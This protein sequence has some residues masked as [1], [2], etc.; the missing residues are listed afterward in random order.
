[1]VRGVVLTVLASVLTI[2]ACD[3]KPTVEKGSG[4]PGGRSVATGTASSGALGAS[5][6]AAY[7]CEDGAYVVA[8][9]RT[10]SDDVALFLPGETVFLPQ[11]EAASGAKYS[12]GALTFWSRAHEAMLGRDGVTVRCIENRQASVIEKAKLGGADFWAA[13]N[14]PGWTL[15][16]YPDR[17][18]LVTA[19]GELRIESPVGP[20]VVDD[21]AGTAVF[22][23]VGSEHEV[24]VTLRSGRCADDMSGRKFE[25]TVGLVVDGRSYRGCGRALH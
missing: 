16:L 8:D 12:D 3:R 19:Y 20:P 6:V 5:T 15:E 13:G 24:T 2:T 1:M 17:L 10:A 25:T 18:V 23:S 22:S 4:A 11:V 7:D 9:F 14:E 21:E